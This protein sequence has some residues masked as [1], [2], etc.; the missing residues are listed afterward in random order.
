MSTHIT[1]RYRTTYAGWNLILPGIDFTKLQFV[2]KK[3]RPQKFA[4]M[5]IPKTTDTY[6]FI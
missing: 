6:I 5:F 4:E 3:I 2:R 1:K